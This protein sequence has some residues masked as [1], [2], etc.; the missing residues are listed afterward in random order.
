MDDTNGVICRSD[1]VLVV[2]DIG[3][4][5]IAESQLLLVYHQNNIVER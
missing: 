5:N 3:L 2:V 4:V 1:A